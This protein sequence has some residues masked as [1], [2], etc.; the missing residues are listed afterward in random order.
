MSQVDPAAE[1]VLDYKVRLEQ[2]LRAIDVSAVTQFCSLLLSARERNSTVFIAGN[3]GSAST[4]NHMVVDWLFG[5]NLAKPSLKIISLVDNVSV[6]TATGNDK[7]FE[8]TVVRPLQALAQ[9]EDILVLV[10]ASG[11]SPNLV[12]AARSARDLRVQV[13]AITG[14]QGGSLSSLSDLEIRVPTRIGDYGV[15]E[16]LH[17][18]IGHMVKEVLLAS[19]V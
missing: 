13:V 10:S 5:T 8:Q 16:D 15:A 7:S 12:L 3:G 18:S 17:L 6:V 4:A 9:P 19:G 14:F 1:V 11:S 2:A